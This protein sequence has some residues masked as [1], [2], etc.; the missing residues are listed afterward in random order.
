M[1]YYMAVGTWET[2]WRRIMWLMILSL[3]AMVLYCSLDLPLFISL[4]GE[5][6]EVELEEVVGQRQSKA[7]DRVG[8]G[9]SGSA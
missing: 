4:F 1:L 2:H 6:H 5:V 9:P 7:V 8:K 3:I